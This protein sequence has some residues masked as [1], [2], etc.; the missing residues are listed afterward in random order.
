MKKFSIQI[1]IRICLI[2]CCSALF[3]YLINLG[4]YWFTA[5]GVLILIALQTFDLYRYIHETNNSLHKFLEAIKNED[6]SV[7][8]SPSKKGTSF[9]TLHTDFNDVLRLFKQNKIEKEAQFK[10]FK[11]IL[12]HVNLG[13]ISIPK[14]VLTLDKSEQEILFINK[15]VNEILGVPMHKYW[16]RITQHIPWFAVEIKSIQNGGKKLISLVEDKQ[17]KN[18]LWKW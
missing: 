13:I 10:H 5:L 16:H 18:F 11:H 7:Y 8:F 2:L 14:E 17:K 15:A 12:E 1:I 3:G 9:N 6:H 4:Q